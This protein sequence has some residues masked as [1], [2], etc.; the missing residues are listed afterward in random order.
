[1]WTGRTYPDAAAALYRIDFRDVGGEEGCKVWISATTLYTG[2]LSRKSQ[3]V[4][5]FLSFYRTNPL[6]VTQWHFAQKNA[7]Q[8]ELKARQDTI[9]IS[10]PRLST[11]QPIKQGVN[12]ESRFTF[13]EFPRRTN[14]NANS[15]LLA[16]S[17]NHVSPSAMR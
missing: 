8:Q 9:Y 10:P 4:S 6:N 15:A 5:L 17:Y 16:Q 3:S 1:M 11:K 13:P 2:K 12:L 14:L 7:R